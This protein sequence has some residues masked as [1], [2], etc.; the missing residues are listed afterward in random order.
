MEP[1]SRNEIIQL[2]S[3]WFDKIEY[4]SLGE[5][6]G[7]CSLCKLGCVCVFVSQDGNA[8]QPR[9]E[10]HIEVCVYLDCN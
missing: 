6:E 3:V 10:Q 8:N 4:R 5:E 2:S 1:L 7:P 9:S